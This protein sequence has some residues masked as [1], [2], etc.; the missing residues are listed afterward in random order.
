MS[1]EMGI[2]FSA[3]ADVL[4]AGKQAAEHALSHLAGKRPDLTL[5]F[6]S[7]RFAGSAAFERYSIRDVERT[8]DWLHRRRRDY[9]LRIQKTECHRHW[10][11]CEGGI[12]YDRGGPTHGSSGTA[13]RRNAGPNVYQEFV[14][15]CQSSG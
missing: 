3:H 13:S 6:S 12:L 1:I 15:R 11:D 8:A 9:G 4:S 2:G 10:S 7:I 5:V 14:E